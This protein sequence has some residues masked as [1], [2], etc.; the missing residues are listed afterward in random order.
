MKVYDISSPFVQGPCLRLDQVVIPLF[1]RRTGTPVGLPPRI[2]LRNA[3]PARSAPEPKS[4]TRSPRVFDIY[5]PRVW[6]AG[7]SF[8]SGQRQSAYALYHSGRQKN[9][10]LAM[11]QC[12][13]R[14][15]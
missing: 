14:R 5:R 6:T 2:N 4:K 7:E 9:R 11:A 13:E 10:I 1:S 8:A 12:G 3:K 15:Q